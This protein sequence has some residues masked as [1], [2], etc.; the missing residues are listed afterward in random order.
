MLDTE[1]YEAGLG[2]KTMLPSKEASKRYEGGEQD[3]LFLNY[4]SK[5]TERDLKDYLDESQYTSLFDCRIDQKYYGF[6]E[7]APRALPKQEEVIPISTLLQYWS[8]PWH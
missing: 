1:D 2:T 5:F 8:Q 4:G 6:F 3:E 7:P